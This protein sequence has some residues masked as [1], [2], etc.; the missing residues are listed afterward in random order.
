MTGDASRVK[1]SA[2]RFSLR[3]GLL[4]SWALATLVGLTGLLAPTGSWAAPPATAPESEAP[5]LIP[6]KP[7]GTV[8]VSYPPALLER[9]EP[10]AGTVIIQYVVGVDGK[11]K[12]LEVLQS[13]DPALDQVALD[14]V[15]ALEFEPASYDGEAVE[16]VLSIGIELGPP[17]PAQ[18]EALATAFAAAL[19]A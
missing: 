9:E 10:P 14:A 15:A 17:T 3:P 19:A 12:E 5:Q 2:P 8:S 16:V 18:G 7:K 1:G 4:G 6:P 11:T 13:V